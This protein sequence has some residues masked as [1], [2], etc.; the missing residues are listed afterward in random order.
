MCILNNEIIFDFALL[1]L[2]L[3]WFCNLLCLKKSKMTCSYHH[4]ADIFSLKISISL[5][6][7]VQWVPPASILT[8]LFSWCNVQCFGFCANASIRIRI[9]KHIQ[10]FPSSKSFFLDFRKERILQ[11]ASLHTSL[12]LNPLIYC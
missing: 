1:L 2:F 5:S 9:A 8:S 10:T 12:P 3:T 4:D 6:K 7:R 11:P